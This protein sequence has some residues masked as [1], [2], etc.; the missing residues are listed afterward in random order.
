MKW[1]QKIMSE[2]FDETILDNEVEF[3]K[4]FKEIERPVF[5]NKIKIKEA[6]IRKMDDDGI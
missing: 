3:K 4:R 5:L 2:D 6:K 1:K